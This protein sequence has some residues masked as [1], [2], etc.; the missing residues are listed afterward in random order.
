LFGLAR[1]DAEP[2]L[3]GSLEGGRGTGRPGVASI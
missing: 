3:A 1:L 2:W